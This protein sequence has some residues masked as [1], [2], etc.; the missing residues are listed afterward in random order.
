MT[1]KRPRAYVC[2]PMAGKPGLNADQFEKARWLVE[3][4]GHEAVVPHNLSPYTH[5]GPCGVVYGPGKGAEAEHDGGCY[6]RGDIAVMVMCEYVFRLP[7]WE[8]NKAPASSPASQSP[9]PSRSWTPTPPS[10]P[11]HPSA[12]GRVE[13]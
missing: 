11:P 4:R 3:Q 12:S 13:P 10:W 2:G 9:S 6:L 5:D 8:H 7:G 1:E